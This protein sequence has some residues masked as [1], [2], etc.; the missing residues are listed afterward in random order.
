MGH[1]F[2]TYL[3]ANAFGIQLEVFENS[4][5]QFSEVP[6]GAVVIDLYDVPHFSELVHE[7][8][9]TSLLAD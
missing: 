6:F 7:K 8:E 3:N 2:A 9:L 5:P 4:Q 1:N